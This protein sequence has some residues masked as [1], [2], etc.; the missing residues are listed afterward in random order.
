MV[1]DVGLVLELVW[2]D[3]VVAELAVVA[4]VVEDGAV[5]VVGVW[6]VTL[7]GVSLVIDCSLE[8]GKTP[9]LHPTRRAEV[10][11]NNATDFFIK[12]KKQRFYPLLLKLLCFLFREVAFMFPTIKEGFSFLI[13]RI[14]SD[15]EEDFTDTEFWRS[16]G[17]INKDDSWS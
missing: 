9:L 6:E 16:F 13:I 5:D 14:T 10:K 4:P 12:N 7:V 17:E 15:S 2:L 3:E 8:V 11:T 1:L